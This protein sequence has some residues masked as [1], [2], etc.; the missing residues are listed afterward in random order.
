MT[1]FAVFGSRTQCLDYVSYLDKYGVVAQAV[2]T[3]K[4]ARVGCGLSARFNSQYKVKAK[5]VLA[6]RKYS[7]FKGFFKIDYS[8]GEARV[9]PC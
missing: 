4:E 1:I 8:F 5:A 2:A 3:P 9:V 6:L 7:S